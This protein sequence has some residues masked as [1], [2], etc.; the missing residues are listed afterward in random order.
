M[1]YIQ[2]AYKGLNDW[3]RYLL[4]I[5]I[6]F[7]GWQILGAIPL[8]L[9]ASFYVKTHLEYMQAMES[10]FMEIGIDSNLFLFLMLFMFVVGLVFLFIGIKSIHKRSITTLITSRKKTDWK[11]VFFAFFL[12]FFVGITT[13]TIGYFSGGS[14]TMTFNFKPMPFLLLVL[15]SFLFMPLQTSFEELLFRGYFMQA[16]GISTINKKFPFIF[17]YSLISIFGLIYFYQSLSGLIITGILILLITFLSLLLN[18][19]LVNNLIKSKLYL[20]L[21]SLL[22]SFIVPLLLTSVAFGLLHGMNPEVEK[23]G[24]IVMVFYIGTGLL[25][26]IL[27]LMDQGTE[28]ALGFHAAN[29]IVAAVFVSQTWTVFQTEA[30]FIDSAEPS[31]GMETFL[32]VFVIYPIILFIFSK[33]YHWTD[34]KGKL[35]GK[36]EKPK[37]KNN[38]FEEDSFL[39]V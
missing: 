33:K 25:L 31:V 19:Q 16:L 20:K 8:F 15:V 18:S 37:I 1:N 28:L 7:F 38:F 35:F 11:R 5:I 23:L 13:L 24:Y 3:W 22:N 9:T 10:M 36:I 2:Q 34:W 39:E 29:N 26:G 21:H 12:W 27:T 6:V 32:P 30:L 14:E 17:L 4:T